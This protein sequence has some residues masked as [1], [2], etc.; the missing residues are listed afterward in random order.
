MI[1]DVH[2]AIAELMI[3]YYGISQ[4][5][6]KDDMRLGSRQLDILKEIATRFRI[7]IYVANARAITVGEF[8]ELCEAEL[9][10]SDEI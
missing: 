3:R 8:K 1:Q 6:I 4:A 7:S 9:L 5:D 10:A 2:Q